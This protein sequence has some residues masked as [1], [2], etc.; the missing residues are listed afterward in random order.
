MDKLKPAELIKLNEQL[1]L[2]KSDLASEINRGVRSLD[3][4]KYWKGSEFRTLLLYIGMVVLKKYLKEKE[5]DHLLK[6]CCATT[7]CTSDTYMQYAVKRE[8][9]S[10][11]T[12][13]GAN[14]K[15]V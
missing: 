10:T 8:S 14:R 2:I 3:N 12:Q 15:I 7:L 4:L 11:T 9:V 5:Y 13:N 6:P 1:E